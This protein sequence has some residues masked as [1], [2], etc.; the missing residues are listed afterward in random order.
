[1]AG[2][3]RVERSKRVMAEQIGGHC[4]QGAAALRE[5]GM[6][7]KDLAEK[8]NVSPQQVSKIVKGKENLTLET[9]SKLEYVLGVELILT[10][11]AASSDLKRLYNE[12]CQGGE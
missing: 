2:E 10:T 12:L 3:G 6:T 7:Q 11:H 1:M 4:I 8:L 9:I 5:K